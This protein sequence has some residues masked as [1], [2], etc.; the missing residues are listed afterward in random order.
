MKCMYFGNC[1]TIFSEKYK[2]IMI[3]LLNYN[4]R[5]YNELYQPKS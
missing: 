2:L 5:L 1:V 4:A 3:R